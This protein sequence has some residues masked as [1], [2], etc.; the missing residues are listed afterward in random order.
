MHTPYPHIPES[1]LAY[2]RRIDPA[3]LPAPLRAQVP[4]DATVWGVHNA[5]GACLALT[6]NRRMAFV[7]ARDNDLSPMSVH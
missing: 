3:T 1:R 5:E 4:P 2:V 6:D 7:V